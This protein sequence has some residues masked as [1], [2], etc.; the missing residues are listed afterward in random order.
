MKK[1]F[2]KFFIPHD[3][4]DH[5]PH[6]LTE[7]VV[8]ILLLVIV[9][10]FGAVA[11]QTKMVTHNADFLAA[12]LP[13]VLVDLA[14]E[15]RSEA[16]VPPLRMNEK[17]QRAAQMKADHMAQHGYF[18]HFSPTG[19]SPWKWIREAGYNYRYAGENLAVNFSDSQDVERAW[20]NSPKHRE[21]ILEHNFT[22]VGIAIARGEYKGQET[23]FVVQMFGRPYRAAASGESSSDRRMAQAE[24]TQNGEVAG[25]Q[26]SSQEKGERE[27]SFI[28]TEGSTTTSS[29]PTSDATSV[30]VVGATDN[31]VQGTYASFFEHLAA[32][33]STLLDTIYMTL[34]VLIALALAG[35]TVVECRRHHLKH[36]FYG[37]SLLVLMMVFTY[38]SRVLLFPNP[39]VI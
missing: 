15:D 19:E 23:V 10:V 21:N 4:N 18:A 17:L 2:K 20:M 32:Q 28:A 34:A 1:H 3:D 7:V 9:G 16:G 39:L 8:G 30:P 31:N 36:A 27:E 29:E 35:L 37:V 11:F 24:D 12:V 38:L 33:P 5:T 26:Q 13:E 22:E 25:E 6:L 14:N